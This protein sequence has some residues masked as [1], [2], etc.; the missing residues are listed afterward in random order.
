MSKEILEPQNWVDLYADMMYLFHLSELKTWKLQN[1][2]GQGSFFDAL[3]TQHTFA[4]KP[5]EKT[6][7]FEILKKKIIGYFRSSTKYISI[8]PTSSEDT[9]RIQFDCSRHRSPKPTNWSMSPE[10]AF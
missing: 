10:K 5:S 3:K 8:D 1:K 2:F 9:D 6:W 4:G 7:L